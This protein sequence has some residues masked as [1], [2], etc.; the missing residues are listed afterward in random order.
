[1]AITTIGNRDL[2]EI[3]RQARVRIPITL[4]KLAA[5]SGVSPS[6]LGRIE[7]GRGKVPLGRNFK[8][9]FQTSRV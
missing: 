7:R 5:M 4:Q 1:M 2:G 3:I 9:N 8:E 6:H